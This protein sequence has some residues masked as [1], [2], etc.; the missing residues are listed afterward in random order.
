MN[1]LGGLGVHCFGRTS[2]LKGGVVGTTMSSVRIYRR[3][4]F[5]RSWHVVG[6]FGGTLTLPQTIS[7]TLLLIFFCSRRRLWC[8]GY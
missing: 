4:T 7:E 8:V 1:G 6:G 5:S 3:K 2:G